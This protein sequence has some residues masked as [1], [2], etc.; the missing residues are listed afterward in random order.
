MGAWALCS[1]S[2]K[3]CLWW[4]LE[5]L[6]MQVGCN[7]PALARAR[8]HTNPPQPCPARPA[9]QEMAEAVN[10]KHR[11]TARLL[12]M[13]PAILP[14]TAD[15]D[16]YTRIRRL[17]NWMLELLPAQSGTWLQDLQVG[18]P[19]AM[20]CLSLTRT[21]RA[22][23]PHTS[24]PHA[25]HATHAHTHGRMCTLVTALA[26]TSRP[27]PSPLAR[28]LQPREV[29][30]VWIGGGTSYLPQFASS[31]TCAATLRLLHCA[32]CVCVR[33]RAC[34]RACV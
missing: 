13:A 34:V 5:L 29:P 23:T 9:A 28:R 30:D 7:A 18:L 6:E 17:I 24:L 8:T 20:P 27:H 4:L 12:P 33:A 3:D 11:S 14:I 10:N 31:A 16:T 21:Q 25:T 15:E 1:S 32:F 26:Q 22:H 19:A 2:D